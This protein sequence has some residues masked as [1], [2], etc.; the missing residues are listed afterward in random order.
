MPRG[1]YN[2]LRE[3]DSTAA[4]ASPF[5]L[6]LYDVVPFATVAVCIPTRIDRL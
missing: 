3:A 6:F 5:P 2:A 4:V 1:P